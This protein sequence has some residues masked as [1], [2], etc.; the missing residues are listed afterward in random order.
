[1]LCSSAKALLFGVA[2]QMGEGLKS[3]IAHTGGLL[4]SRASGPT[5][6]YNITSV[7]RLRPL[8]ACSV[9]LLSV[10]GCGRTGC[11]D[12][13]GMLCSSAMAQSTRLSQKA[14]TTRRMLCSI[15][16][17]EQAVVVMVGMVFLLDHGEKWLN[18]GRWNGLY[19]CNVDAAGHQ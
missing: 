19:D 15:A 3:I 7:K 8:D 12:C 16:L 4:C 9:A 10:V 18:W 14:A 13:G 17:C 6:A 11:N 5:K 2:K 1:V